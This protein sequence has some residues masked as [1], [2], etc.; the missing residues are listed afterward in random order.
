[1][2]IV[3]P[4]NRVSLL[5]TL[6]RSL[7]SSSYGPAVCTH[8]RNMLVKIGPSSRCSNRRFQSNSNDSA[9]F[10]YNLDKEMYAF[11]NACRRPILT[12]N[13][14]S[15]E[16]IARYRDNFTN[17]IVYGIDSTGGYELPQSVAHNT[18]IK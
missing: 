17:D 15:I 12:K 6:R 18:P 9:S 13:I 11:F 14:V 3:V 7:Y 4:F 5:S 8:L 2:M 10:Y 1:M 16:D